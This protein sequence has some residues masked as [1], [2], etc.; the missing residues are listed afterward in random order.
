MARIHTYIFMTKD[1]DMTTFTP[2]GLSR[3]TVLKSGTVAVGAM[4]FAPSILRAQGTRVRKNMM[5]KGGLID[6]KTYGEGVALMLAL[7]MSDARN[8]YRQGMLHFIDCPHGNWWFTSWHRGYLGYLEDIIREL[9]QKEEFMLPY[10]DWTTSPFVPD[11]MFG[12]DNPLDPVNFLSDTANY[13]P[14]QKEFQAAV[15]PEMEAFWNNMTDAQIDQQNKRK[16]TDFDIMWR[17]K[18]EDNATFAFQGTQHARFLTKD[19]SQLDARTQ[20][21]VALNNVLGNLAPTEFAGDFVKDDPY[22]ENSA[23][24]SHQ[25]VGKFSGLSGTHNLV[26]NNTG[27][28]ED[29]DGNYVKPYGNMTNNLSPLDPIFFL[30]HGNIDRLW[31]VWTRK[32][33]A[34][35]LSAQPSDDLL[36]RYKAE[37]YLFFVDR[38]GDPIPGTPTSWDYFETSSFDYTYE[39][40]SGE[41]VVQ[42][43][44]P[45][46]MAKNVA[47]AMVS[48]PTGGLAPMANL[49]VPNALATSVAQPL[50]S[51]V[52]LATVRFVPPAHARGKVFD[53]Y[54]SPQGQSPI[55]GADSPQLASSFA[56]FG[57]AHGMETGFTASIDD[58]LDRLT[59][60]GTLSEG[61]ELSFSLVIAGTDQTIPVSVETNGQL[62]SVNLHVL[63]T[64]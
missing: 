39:P 58:A 41:S 16:N 57:H 38:H 22:F 18:K 6:L 7:P 4:V 51:T 43:A 24:Q 46:A 10:W 49:V 13:F 48:A 31:D 34:R 21:L 11:S 26:H 53:L 25:T 30:H 15:R 45:L 23:T 50:D 2:P 5:S 47:M 61:A 52:H 12:A 64:N 36:E 40:G 62:R 14:T 1:F 19:N 20:K 63:S 55:L 59:A 9:T 60:D 37:P 28:S 44:A 17:T 3:R 35:G 32:Q 56:F 27:G 8:W 33:Q 29:A 42:P 54:I